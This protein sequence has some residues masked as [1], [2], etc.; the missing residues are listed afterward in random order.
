Y[1]I[2][3]R[4]RDGC[5]KRIVELCR[6]AGLIITEAGAVYPY[7]YDPRDRDLR[8]APTYLQID[9]LKNAMDIF[10]ASVKL[11]YVGKMES[12]NNSTRI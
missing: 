2:H 7:G 3:F 10:C 1:F 5:A 9:E 8:I 4:S 11:S 12:I 6:G